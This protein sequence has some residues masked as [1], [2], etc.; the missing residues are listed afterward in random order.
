M[1]QGALG[2]TEAP[3]P[4]AVT[5][6]PP[7]LVLYDGLCGLCHR[8]VRFLLR[9]DR[10]HKLMFAPLQGTT[11]EA[12]RRQYAELEQADLDSVIF[13]DAGRVFVRSR[14]LVMAAS[15]LPAPWRYA[16]VLRFVPALIAD[17]AY[18]FVARIRYRIWGRFDRCTSPSPEERAR[19]LP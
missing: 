8:T 1:A 5:P 13:V 11:A 3:L 17:L 14:A 6:C 10:A 2:H 16:K 12:L 15:H 18:R 19:F 9:V 4:A 7:R